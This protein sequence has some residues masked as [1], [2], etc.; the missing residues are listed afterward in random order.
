MKILF[1]I[2]GRSAT[3]KDTLT[4]RLCEELDMTKVVSHTTREPRYGEKEGVHYFFSAAD[5][6]FAAKDANN[7]AA[8]TQIGKNL[9][10]TTKDEILNK[11]FYVIDP[12]GFKTLKKNI[13]NE[14]I[15]LITIY[16]TA[17]TLDIEKRALMRDP[18]SIMQFMNKCEAEDA[19]FS[20]YEQ[21]RA[22]DYC[23]HNAHFEIALEQL[24]TIIRKEQE[25][26][27]AF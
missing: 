12:E 25:N 7:I 16:I 9:Y 6:L 2:I 24:K 27:Y 20:E 18:S 19:Q 15:R 23:V 26:C 17:P 5:E 13:S 22:Y 10:W 11:D 8:E 3:G 21:W 4:N 14:Q 1:C